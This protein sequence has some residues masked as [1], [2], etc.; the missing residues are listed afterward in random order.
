MV[1]HH[2]LRARLWDH[3][4]SFQAH[5][6]VNLKIAKQE[7]TNVIRRAKNKDFSFY[8]QQRRKKYI[9]TRKEVEVINR[10]LLQGRGSG[11]SVILQGDKHQEL[12]FIGNKRPSPWTH[13]SFFGPFSFN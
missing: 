12:F 10:L 1:G 3:A 9:E 4:V 8:S 11:T 6:K 5:I 2:H 7:K 13:L